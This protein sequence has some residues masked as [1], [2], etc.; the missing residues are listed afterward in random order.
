MSSARARALAIDTRLRLGLQSTE[1][2]DVYKAASTFHITCIKRPLE[3]NVSGATFKVNDTVS[4]ILVNSSK[5]LGHQNFTVAHELFHCLY[6]EGIQSRA[7]HVEVFKKKPASEQ[8]AELFAVHLL[9][10][11]D[12]IIN[13][14][15]IREKLDKKPDLADVIHLEQYFG[16]S[17]RAMCW[18]LEEMDLISKYDSMEFSTNVIQSAKLLGK[19]TS[20]Y[21]PTHET[22]L[23]SDCAEKAKEAFDKG[24]I[25]N[26]RY[27]EIL[28][29]AGLLESLLAEEESGSAS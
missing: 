24:L 17:R 16:V 18:R 22:V 6:D 28:A 26:S 13:Q 11:E 2:I 12:G 4:I 1:Y 9:M 19:D 25:T 27:E 8:I 10:P 14:L 3:S 5:S 29:D 23:L 7:C 21:E 15:K 20:L